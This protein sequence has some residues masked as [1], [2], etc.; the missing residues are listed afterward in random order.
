MK[1]C[2][3]KHHPAE[4]VLEYLESIVVLFLEMDFIIFFYKK[5]DV[6]LFC[7]VFP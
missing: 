4:T 2:R 6:A 7:F 5:K 3:E 1:G